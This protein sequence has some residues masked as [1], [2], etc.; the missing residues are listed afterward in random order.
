MGNK[1]TE[2]ALKE[3]YHL[4]PSTKP[5]SERINSEVPSVAT[6]IIPDIAILDQK[7]HL[8]SV[9]VVKTHFVNEGCLSFNQIRKLLRDAE[10]FLDTEPNL[11]EIPSKA[12]VVGD[13]HGQFY[14]LISILD[15]FNLKRDV[16]VFLGD[17]VDRG[18]FSTE[19]YLYLMLLKAHYPCNIYLLR[20][21][22]ESEKMTSYFTMKHECISKYSIDIY[23]RIVESFKHLP[24][25]AIIQK[26][27]YCAHGGISPHL[28]AVHDIN[29]ID[30]F[31]EVEYKGLMC[32]VLWSDPHPNYE[33]CS[34]AWE[35]NHRRRC[36]VF[37][38]YLHVANFLAKNRLKMIVRG[39]EVQ[40]NGY[41]EFKKHQKTPS[42][43]TVF[44][45][46]NYCDIYNNKGAII[47][48]DQGRIKIYTYGAVRH[49]YVH[50]GFIDGIEWSMPFISQKI[51]EF[52]MAVIDLIGDDKAIDGQNDPLVVPDF[53]MEGRHDI[54]SVVES[55]M[56]KT[57]KE[58]DKGYSRE[59]K[60]LESIHS[61]L[62]VLRVEKE[63]LTEINDEDSACD[64]DFITAPEEKDQ[65]FEEV[66]SNDAYNKR[67][68]RL[69]YSDEEDSLSMSPSQ[70]R[71]IPG[72]VRDELMRLR[73]KKRSKKWYEFWK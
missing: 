47:E 63:K 16:L 62:E 31:K 72:E 48:Y 8:L 10:R 56:V 60:E 12:F 51:V 70:E 54:P 58:R 71:R 34:M 49:P 24:L 28:N 37:Y 59:K 2:L 1:V 68:I 36:S 40:E 23:N 30:R 3:Y 5:H 42:V 52:V 4:I 73:I 20:G 21:N 11:L 7:H 57:V 18:V 25:A 22:H 15:T 29:K 32:D 65:D 6:H 50:P 69:K 66:R 67:A 44:S 35:S 19:T 53:K 46:P 26:E 33:D 13:I 41:K 14:D 27:V 61:S 39:H 9:N 64:P 55:S 45:A 38:G 17:Y 43:M